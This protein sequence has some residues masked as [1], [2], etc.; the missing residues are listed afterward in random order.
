MPGL[1]LYFTQASVLKSVKH[2]FNEELT[3]PKNTE[4]IKE[5]ESQEKLFLIRKGV[6]AV[7]KKIPCKDMFGVVKLR[8]EK[9]M[10]LG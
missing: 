3:F 6:A 2:E 4:I 9:I 5:G 7:F 10:T 8:E 1:D